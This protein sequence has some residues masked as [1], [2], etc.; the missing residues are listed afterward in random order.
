[1]DD[2]SYWNSKKRPA[3]EAVGV[4]TDFVVVRVS[5]TKAA[6]ESLLERG[7]DV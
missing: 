4:V 5:K 1:M 7:V 3:L 2:V 6:Y